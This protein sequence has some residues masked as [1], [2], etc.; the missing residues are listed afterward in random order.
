MNK[1]TLFDKEEK[2]PDEIYRFMAEALDN[3]E[4]VLIQS[5]RAMNRAC[6]VVA[7]FVMRRYKWCLL[8]TLEFV[9]SRRQDLEMRQSFLQ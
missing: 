8:K 2:I 6:F 7:A 3:Y 9:N 1:Q 4:S 5:V